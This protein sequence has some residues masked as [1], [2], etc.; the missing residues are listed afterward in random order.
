MKKLYSILILLLLSVGLLAACGSGNDD[1]KEEDNGE[2]KVKQTETG[3]PVTFKDASGEEIT[4]EKEPQRIV[5]LIPSNT[6]TA[7]ALGV[8]D[9]IV[10]RSEWD[11]YPE[12]V[13]EIESIGDQT[14]NVEKILSLNPDMVLGVASHAHNSAEGVKQLKDAGIA[15]VLIDEATSFEQVYKSIEMI[16]KATGANEKATEIIDGMKERI[17]AVKKKTASITEKK[18]VV[19]EINLEPIF[20]AG[21]NTFM[22]EI[23]SIINAENAITEE[24]WPELDQ[25]ALIER[26]PDIIITTYGYYVED[27]VKQVM[28]RAGWQDIMAVKE[29]QVYDVHS[30]L[31]SRPGPRLVEG[32]EEVAKVVY[33]EV[34]K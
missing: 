15:V 10:G 9:K 5:S 4:I 19:F 31:V 27:P 33:P 25:E 24:G 3:F 14:M 8:G 7:F 26:N 32:V 11:N 34:F 17:A 13:L 2:D 21:A 23:L 22:D 12:E 30:D 1:A 28:D 20:V 18:T 6:E 29:E 16:G